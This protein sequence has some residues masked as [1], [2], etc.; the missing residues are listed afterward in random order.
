MFLIF[1]VTSN[2][3]LFKESCEF[4]VGTSDFDDFRHCGDAT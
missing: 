1:H 3:H 2:N 4:M